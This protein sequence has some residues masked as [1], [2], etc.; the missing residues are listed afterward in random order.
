MIIG[1]GGVGRYVYHTIEEINAESAQWNVIGFID[2]DPSKHHLELCGREVLG[3]TDWLRSGYVSNVVIAIGDP[4]ARFRVVRRLMSIRQLEYP[5]II[6]PR[7]WISRSV[8]IGQGVIIYPG[9]TIDCDVRIGNFSII[10]K[11][12]VVGHDVVLEDFSTLSPSV[13]IGG[14]SLLGEGAF[15]GIGSCTIQHV[16]I[17]RWSVVGAGATVISNLPE[18]VVAVGVPAKVIKPNRHCPGTVTA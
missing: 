12:S 1:T 2:D 10:N 17:G 9:V 6:H 13:S 15:M 4:F 3:G 14:S 8:R 16:T 5:A 18:R 7:A 11:Q